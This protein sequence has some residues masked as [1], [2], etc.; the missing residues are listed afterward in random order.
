MAPPEL[1]RDTPVLNLLQPSEPL[2]LGLLWR[3]MKLAGPCA[4]WSVLLFNTLKKQRNGTYLDGFLGERLAV[5]PPLGL[6]DGLDNVAGL[7]V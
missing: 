7:T 3:Y 4:L 1:T 5:H 6:E 2:G